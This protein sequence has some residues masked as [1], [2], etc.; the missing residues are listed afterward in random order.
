MSEKN[1]LA[2]FKS[3][4]EAEGARQK[5]Q[6]LRVIDSSVER[7]DTYPGDGIDRIMNPVTGDFDGL[8]SLTLKGDFTNKSAQ[9]LTAASPDA[10]GMGVRGDEAAAGRDVLLTA[11]VPEEVYEQ[12]I[13]VI[14]EAGGLV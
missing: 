11:V 12:C 7:I 8:G 5:L 3:P 13:K 6:S 9:I 2:Y 4:E 1:I 10:S 14:Q